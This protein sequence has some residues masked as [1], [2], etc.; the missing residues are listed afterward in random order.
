MKHK[1]RASEN[2]L[3]IEVYGN[4]IS[5]KY[6]ERS[7]FTEWSFQCSDALP[8][9]LIGPSGSGKSTLLSLLG[10]YFLPTA[11][12]IVYS[13]WDI[14]YSTRSSSFHTFARDHIGTFFT[15]GSFFESHTARENIDFP[16]LFWWYRFSWEIYSELIDL[17]QMTPELLESP[18]SILSSGERERVNLIRLFVSMPRILLLDE[19]F[20]H[21]D[22]ELLEKALWF[23]GEYSSQYSPLCIIATHML[24]RFPDPKNII[25]F[26]QNHPP[27]FLEH[28]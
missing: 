6:S 23:L 10:G 9:F 3:S 2:T 24:D 1:S 22:D 27:T 21:L 19:P 28:V 20:S 13:Y 25:Q 14:Q 12:E 8:T 16:H 17:F 26:H 15:E 4:Q 7:L 5:Q 18:V 11:W